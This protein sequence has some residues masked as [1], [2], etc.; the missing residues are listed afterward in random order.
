MTL[1]RKRAEKAALDVYS[2]LDS[3]GVS[4]ISE[5]YESD[6]NEEESQ[7]ESEMDNGDTPKDNNTFPSP[8]NDKELLD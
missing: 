4:D 3:L 6:S 5:V 1:Q 2:Y 7:C 8:E